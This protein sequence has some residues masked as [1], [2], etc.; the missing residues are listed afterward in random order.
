MYQEGAD[1][2][3]FVLPQSGASH[4]F[5]ICD[6]KW[7]LHSKKLDLLEDSSVRQ[8]ADFFVL[9]GCRWNILRIAAVRGITLVHN[10]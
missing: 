5:I 3:F 6:K 1:E 2:K 8:R 9:R 7:G 4:L 10:L